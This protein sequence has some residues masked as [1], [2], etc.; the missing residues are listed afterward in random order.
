MPVY[1]PE[2][3]RS[4]NV[5]GISMTVVSLLLLCVSA[6]LGYYAYTLNTN[7][8]NTTNA[9][10]ALQ[11]E[12]DKLKADYATLQGDNSKLNSD[13]AALQSELDA[14][15]NDLATAQTD[16][17]AA[18]DQTAAL[19]TKIEAALRRLD[20]LVGWWVEDK[21]EKGVEADIRATRDTKLLDLFQTYLSSS[22]FNDFDRWLSYL[23]ESIVNELD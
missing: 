17:Q 21:T 12:H 6:G 15:K 11:A 13:I 20:V 23:I 14:T 19:Q 8:T 1:V 2:K 4:V 18:K 16:L 10:A 22:N 5:F 3:K 7:L 9:L